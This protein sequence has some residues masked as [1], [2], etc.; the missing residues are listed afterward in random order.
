MMI[1]SHLLEFDENNKATVELPS[2]ANILSV[3]FHPQTGGIFTYVL[4]DEQENPSPT[5]F[6]FMKVSSGWRLDEELVDGSVYVD[7]LLLPE[8]KVEHVLYSFEI[9][10]GME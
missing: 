9:E 4:I 6:T 10:S 1:E 7:T 5:R 8:G 2:T 3:K